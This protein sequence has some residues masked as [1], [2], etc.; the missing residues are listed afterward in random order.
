MQI[1]RNVFIVEQFNCSTMTTLVRM[2]AKGQLV[3]P[4]DVR[5]ELGLKPGDEFIGVRTHDG[6]LFRKYYDKE[7]VLA[8]FRKVSDEISARFKKERITPKDLEDA[9]TWSRA[10]SSTR[11]SSSRQSVGKARHVKRSKKQ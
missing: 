10:S 3:V 5:E 9:I 11:T 1:R 8:H 4:Q 2:S 7:K 6:I